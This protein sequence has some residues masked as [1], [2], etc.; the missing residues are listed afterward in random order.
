ML[1][2][3]C[4]FAKSRDLS[5]DRCR[6]IDVN[7]KASECPVRPVQNQPV[8]V[9]MEVSYMILYSVYGQSLGGF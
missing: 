7:S 2:R 5:H 4:E 1:K 8:L 3:I 6:E 9:D